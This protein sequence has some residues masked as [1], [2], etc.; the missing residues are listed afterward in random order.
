[1]SLVDD[2]EILT[3]H[4]PLSW[5]TRL[6]RDG[7]ATGAVPHALD[8]PTGLGKTMVMALWLLARAAGAPV[9]R[10]LVYV[11]DRR[12]VV[13]QAS[14]VADALREAL[15][16]R[17]ELS[18]MKASLGLTGHLPIS[19]LRGAHLDRGEWLVD[20]TAP[21]I[22]VGTVDMIGSRLLF[23]GYGVSRAMRP[24]HA[25]LLG[26][27]SLFVLDE[28]HL[29]PPFE[30]LMRALADQGASGTGPHAMPPMRVLS[31]SATGRRGRGEP[32]RLIPADAQDA[33]VS[34]RVH[35]PKR[36]TVVDQG[37]GKPAEALA[38]QAKALMAAVGSPSTLVV[39]CDARLTAVDVGNKLVADGTVELFVGARRYHER[40]RVATRLADLGFL[41][42]PPKNPGRWSI[43]V[44]TSAGEVG[45]DMDATHAVCDLVPWERMVQRL[46]RVN[47]RGKDRV[48]AQ[49]VVVAGPDPDDR[50]RAT[51]ALLEA[52]PRGA[53]DRLDASPSAL[54]ALATAD[55][56]GAAAATTPAPLHP[57]VVPATIDAWAMTSL[58]EHP[59]RPDVAPW[60]RGWVE[61]EPQTRVLWR[62]ILPVDDADGVPA[63]VVRAYFEAVPP[64]LSEV[65][66][67][68]TD[69]VTA[70]LRKRIA[71]WAK[72]REKG[73]P[74]LV[75]GFVRRAGDKDWAA[76]RS[77]DIDRLRGAV[78]VLR[79]ADGGLTDGLL[80]ADA[81]GPVP[82]GDEPAAGWPPV[83]AVREVPANAPTDHEDIVLVLTRDGE[84]DPVRRLAVRLRTDDDRPEDA[85]A[86]TRAAV[87]L[88]DHTDHVTACAMGFADRLG[89]TPDQR[90][91]LELAAR[92]HDRGKAADRWQAAFGIP[93]GRRPMAKSSWPLSIPMLAGYRHE[94]GSLVEAERDPEI[95]ALPAD[96]RDLVLHLIAAHHGHA[97]PM[98]RPDGCAAGPPSEL[99]VVSTRAALRF[100]RLHRTW[101]PWGLAW[102][103][104]L[105]R[106][107]DMAASRAEAKGSADG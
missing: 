11:V 31:L 105:L 84:G 64:H 73:A 36:L 41:T 7:L 44:A 52:L 3:G 66:E 80:D 39:Y 58:E 19:T 78:L 6:L 25:G 75:L 85:R 88:D 65:L 34:E 94:F 86:R 104:A 90:R 9:P 1:M 4:R 12:A 97:R 103:E 99:E 100:A 79:A 32:F 59:G 33:I 38:A 76:F 47:R 21:A 40:D 102:W 82:A 68:E 56:E 51:R 29:V 22:I 71:L 91:T 48:G 54:G 77:D 14:S 93:V 95:A 106:T 61:D 28:A 20:P 53:D 15:E 67:T 42:D 16:R 30:A 45:V 60:L 26:V 24:I 13:D 107:A 35:A 74:P 69:L 62:A 70:W 10:R 2:F 57:P 50:R 43:L 27:D 83:A 8:L 96:Q 98:I 72:G 92:W 81:T 87:R 63:E 18:A 89:L 5:Q 55:P 46:G 49:V 17:P 101:G 23:E 37:A